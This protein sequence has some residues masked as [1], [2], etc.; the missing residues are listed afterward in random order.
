M[1]GACS[2][3]GDEKY[4]Q[5][6]DWNNNSQEYEYHF[7]RLWIPQNL[8]SSRLIQLNQQFTQNVQVKHLL[9]SVSQYM[10]YGSVIIE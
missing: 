4:I 7:L 3:H 10:S 1:A 8:H 6:L 9:D 5:I 2:T